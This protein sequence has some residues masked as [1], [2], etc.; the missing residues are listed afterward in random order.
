M[1]GILMQASHLPASGSELIS[2]KVGD[3][4]FAIDIMSVRE[5]RGWNTSTPLPH[6]PAYVLGMINLRGA[7]LPV[8]DLS[9]RLGLAPRRPDSS[10]VV[11]VAELGGRPVGLLVDAVCDIVT[12]N[13]GE[14]QAPPEVG[15]DIRFVRGVITLG[16]DII[17]LLDLDDALPP[18]DLEAAA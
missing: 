14:L 12:L 2:V 8:L 9:A 3:Q 10:S 11:V 7:V 17:I 5:I 15:A 16:Q 4:L 18:L 6:A 13:D 1:G